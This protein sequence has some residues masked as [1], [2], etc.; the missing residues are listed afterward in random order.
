MAQRRPIREKLYAAMDPMEA[1]RAAAGSAADGALP[2]AAIPIS[3]Q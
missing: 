2:N 3:S 1:I